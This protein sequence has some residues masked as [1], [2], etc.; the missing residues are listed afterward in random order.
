MDRRERI[1][2]P[3]ESLRMAL[4]ALQSKIFT[5]LPG[6]ITAVNLAANTVSVQSTIQG[7]VQNQEG[8]YSNTNMP[9]LVDVP[10]C[11]PKGGGFAVTFP[12]EAG[13]E[14]LVV[15]ASRCIDG[16]WQSGG[17]SPPAEDR[18]HDLS[19]GFAVLAPSS[20]AK[21]ITNVS[22]NTIQIRTYDGETLL[23]ITKDG[24]INLTALEI[25]INADTLNV[26]AANSNFS[27]NVTIDGEVIGDGINLGTHKHPGVQSG[28]DETGEP[29]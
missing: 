23:E 24:K 6:V 2:D 19:D 22:S 1:N 8:S 20:L 3:E 12:V 5:A 21:K 11:F 13:D 29:I 7:Q 9:L 18:M 25:N 26:N 28:P 15:F 4:D 27:G 17:V 16:W 10:I 14:V